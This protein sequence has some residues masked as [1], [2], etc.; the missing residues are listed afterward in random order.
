MPI[1]GVYG[2]IVA[3]LIAIGGGVGYKIN[4]H[5]A[6][7]NLTQCETE[8]EIM[9]RVHRD[10]ATRRIKKAAESTDKVMA[11]VMNRIAEAEKQNQEARNELKKYT[12]GRDCLSGDARRVL[13]SAPAFGKQRVS[14][15]TALTVTG[16]ATAA[17]DPGNRKGSA[18]AVT[19]DTDIAGWIGDA[20]ELYAECTARLEAIEQWDA[21]ING[22]R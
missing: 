13:E 4:D 9:V 5:F 7:R 18:S 11:Y 16:A 2:M 22:R 10:E 12:T 21:G 14:E 20:S 8:K 15:N 3:I 6:S 17:A 19:T 1:L